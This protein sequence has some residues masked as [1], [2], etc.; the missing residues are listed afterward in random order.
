MDEGDWRCVQCGQYYY[1]QLPDSTSGTAHLSIEGIRPPQEV[2]Q[3][4]PTPRP[5]SGRAPSARPGGRS[6][7][8]YDRDIGSLIQSN[9]TAE[10]RW[11]DR[12]RYIIDHLDRGLS[13]A[14]I[15]AL[16]SRGK[17]EIRSVRERLAE[18][19][20]ATGTE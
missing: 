14:E 8:K 17:R 11:W 9:T 3:A 16:T 2:E 6:R 1:G 18:M 5:S 7:A 12:N 13:I 10:S 15:A 4:E 19:R 20:A